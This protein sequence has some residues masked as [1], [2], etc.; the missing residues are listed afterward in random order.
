MNSGGAALL[1]DSVK[2]LIFPDLQKLPSHTRERTNCLQQLYITI[3]ILLR[4]PRFV[5]VYKPVQKTFAYLSREN[6]KP[7]IC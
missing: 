2:L 6:D 1:K 4:T 3:S 5:Q 7:T